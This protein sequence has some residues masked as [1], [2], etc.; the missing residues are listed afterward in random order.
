MR[1]FILLLTVA[2]TSVALT[3]QL[4]AKS[5][6]KSHSLKRL[7]KALEKK[8]EEISKN[9]KDTKEVAK[10]AKARKRALRE[11]IRKR[12]KEDAA[13]VFQASVNGLPTKIK[14]NPQRASERQIYSALKRQLI[15]K[16]KA[17]TKEES[18]RW[19]FDV[20]TGNLKLNASKR[21]G[22][23]EIKAGEINVYKAARRIAGWVA[24][25]ACA[26]KE[27]IQKALDSSLDTDDET[28]KDED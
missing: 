11:E 20:F 27:C 24:A 3:V 13:S 1:K 28:D 23:G 21:L 22:S 18:S 2:L 7:E 17:E 15:D 14:E 5:R 10:K 26:W 25:G 4:D 12:E 16:A 8:I 19:E 6:S 9:L